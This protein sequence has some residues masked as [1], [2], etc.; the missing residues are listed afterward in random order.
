VWPDLVSGGR[1]CASIIL[2][3]AAA[4]LLADGRCIEWGLR[5][6]VIAKS[7]CAL[8]PAKMW[9]NAERLALEHWPDIERLTG[10]ALAA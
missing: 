4:R 3:G 9:A 7:I 5:E 10:V 2:S 6:E 8:K 1:D